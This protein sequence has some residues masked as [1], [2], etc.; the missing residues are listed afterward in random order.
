MWRFYIYSPNIIKLYI[1]NNLLNFVGLF[2]DGHLT[3][4]IDILKTKKKYF[5]FFNI[6]NLRKS[7]PKIRDPD[8][9]TTHFAEHH[10]P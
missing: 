6:K 9:K 7:M 4:H 1:A 8:R 10:N 2:D 5:Y 3:N